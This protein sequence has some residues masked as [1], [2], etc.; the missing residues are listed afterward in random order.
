MPHYHLIAFV[1]ACLVVI[2]AT[3]IVKTVGLKS[4]YVDL[5]NPRKVHQRPMVRL[6]GVSIFIGNLL[7]LLLV[8]KMG[9]FGVLPR[10]AEYE[11]WGVTVGGLLFFLIGL[12]DDLFTL[13]PLLRLGLQFSVATLAWIV[14]VR[15]EF[16]TIPG[17]GLVN[18]DWFSLP[19]TAI[20]LVGMA[21]AINFIDGLDGL[22]AGVSGIAA[23]VMLFVSLFMHQSAA[24]LVAAALA[25]GAL[26][27]LRYNFNPAQIFMGDG[28]AYFLGF[29]LAGIGVIGVVKGVTTVAVLLPF[30]I[31]AVPIVDTSAVVVDRLRSG[32]SPFAADK[33]HLHHRL[34]K[35]GLSQ[36][37]IALFIYV[38]TLWVGSLAIAFAGIPGGPLYAIG[39]TLILGWASWQ[40]WKR[41]RTSADS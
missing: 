27:F 8:W 16:F 14:G 38:L 3:P 35:A 39:S 4:G 5:P 1:A 37:A 32:Q 19:F 40:V 9:A 20:W 12:A 36:R 28:G 6:G 11:I 41:I 25:G 10:E 15:I 7:A 31:L 21:N 29:T 30:L 24:A 23:V 17:L 18:L 2:C 13:P 33:R 26:G 34:L 22:A